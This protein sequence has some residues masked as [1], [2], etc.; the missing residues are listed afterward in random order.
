MRTSQRR[1]LSHVGLGATIM[2]VI[3]CA[4]EAV[5]TTAPGGDTAVE[6]RDGSV[7]LA[8]AGTAEPAREVDRRPTMQDLPIQT[9]VLTDQRQGWTSFRNSPQQLGIAD[10]AL[11]EELQLL[12]E[13]PAAEGVKSTPAIGAGR[14]YVGTV[15]GDLLCLD[16]RTGALVWKYRSIA[17]ENPEDF[18]P[19]F[20]APVTITD[21]LVL[22]GDQDGT[23]HAV[24]RASGQ[25]RWVFATNGE[26]VGGATVIG[27]RVLF[28]SHA[29][30]LFCLDVADGRKVWE[31]QT[32]GPVN[33]AQAVA[34]GRTFVVGCSEPI[35][36]VVDIQ[37]GEQISEVPIEG[38]LIATPAIA[39]DI[40]YFG[41]NEG[42]VFAVDWQ[43]QTTLWRYADPNRTFEIHSSPAVTD[44]RVIIGSRDKRLH[45]LDR[46]SGE[47]VWTFATSR[48]STVRPSCPATWS[49]LDRATSTFTASKCRTA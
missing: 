28:G 20:N 33:G 1:L 41:T 37:T 25:Q 18:A 12:W 8:A 24:D 31:F 15:D 9:E 10:S 38:L 2:L 30:L 46:T 45:C 34:G 48:V 14:V 35:L 22:A 5:D 27:Q 44:D 47:R 42:G 43:Q 3:G 36:R 7:D 4:G 39:D 26:I 13:Y 17:S 11:P 40:L 49:S 16:L 21:A 32:L 29:D 23:L 6:T 19:S